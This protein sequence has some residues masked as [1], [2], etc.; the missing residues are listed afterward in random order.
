MGFFT[1][2]D[3]NK[4]KDASSSSGLAKSLGAL[5][6]ITLGLGAII[7]TGVFVLTGTVAAKYSGPAISLSYAIAGLTCIFVALTYT[8][9][10]TMLP[11][12]G[13]IYTYSYVALGEGFA[14]LMGSIIMIELGFGAATVAAGWS[15]Y[16]QSILESGGITIPSYLTAVPADGGI[17]NL[18]A[19][20]VMSFITFMLVLGTKDSKKLNTALVFVK[21]GAI[22]AFLICAVPY[23]DMEKNIQ[24]FMPFGFDDVIYGASVLFFAFTGFGTLATAAE[25]CK[26]PR[27]DLTIGIIGSLLLATLVYVVIAFVVTAIAPYDALNNAQPLAHALKLNGNN[28]GSSLV[29]TG[30]VA[31][32]TTVML[33]QMYGLTRIFYVMARDGLMPQSFAKLHAKYDSP[34]MAV[35]VFGVIITL[36]AGFL[37]YDILGKLSSMGALIDYIF[38]AVIVILFRIVRPAEERPFKCPAIFAVAPVTLAACLYLLFKQII[39][40]EGN[41]LLTGEIIIIWFVAMIALYFVRQAFASNNK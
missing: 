26:N 2:K 5:D 11:T 16:I 21:L 14:W 13:S 7:G 19:M 17:V 24:V 28:V 35:I 6:L 34:Y 33:M 36:M 31:G 12:S 37:P 18:P 41:L 10:A 29:A 40:K 32:M 8:E 23:I 3:F 4:V 27:R 22:L 20:L 15:A 30:A 38:V 9:L 1:K 25:E 39:G